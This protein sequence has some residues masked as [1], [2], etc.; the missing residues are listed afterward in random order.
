M[1]NISSFITNENNLFSELLNNVIP[2]TQQV[3]MLVGY[4]YFSG[5]GEIAEALRD[6]DVKILVGLK[7]QTKLQKVIH[8]IDEKKLDQSPPESREKIRLEYFS[9]LVKLFN[10]SEYFDSPDKQKAFELFYEKLKD[11]SLE[12]RKTDN[13]NHA[14]IYLF[15]FEDDRGGTSPGRVITGSSNLTYS[16]LSGRQEFN[17]QLYDPNHYREAKRI[18]KE[19]WDRSTVIA[20]EEY[21]EEFERKV[22]QNIWHNKHDKHTPYHLFLRVLK[23]Y[24]D[25]QENGSI[26][27]CEQLTGGEYTDLK[28]QKDAI[29]ESLAKIKKHDGVIVSDVAGLGK[30]IIA[31]TLAANLNL[32]TVVICPPAI[33]DNWEEYLR[34]FNLKGKAYSSG[35]IE[36]ALNKEIANDHEKLIIIDE[37]HKYRNQETQDY[38]HLYQLC[39]GQKLILLS[40]TPF[41]NRPADIFSLIKFFQVP[42][43]SS[44]QTVENLGQEFRHL[45]SRYKKIN[46][47]R[48]NNELTEEEKNRGISEISERIRD[49]ISPVIIRRSRVDLQK[50]EAY[51]KDLKQQGFQLNKMRPPEGLHYD[52]RDNEKLYVET[53]NQIAEEFEG[54]RY[55][56]ASY[57]DKRKKFK[58]RIK[59]DFGGEQLLVQSQKNLANFMKRHLISRFE[60]SVYAF[61]ISLSRMIRDAEQIKRYYEELDCIPVYK[62]GKLPEVEILEDL[63]AEEADQERQSILAELEDLEDEGLETISRSE[64]A[65]TQFI[66]KLKSDIRLLKKIR[67]EW[68]GN[69]DSTNSLFSKDYKLE[70]FQD[71]LSDKLSENSQRKIVV[72]SE[73]ADTVNYLRKELADRGFHVFSY[74]A[75]DA[76]K[77]N[78]RTIKHNFDANI[79]RDLWEDEYD[80]LLATDTLSEGID[81]NRAGIVV[82]YDIP[83]NP[84]RVI[85]RVG[86]INRIS[87]KLFDE[88]EIYHYFPTAQ[89][90]EEIRKK[91]IATLKMRMMNEI[92]GTDMKVLTDEEDIK[93][94]YE[95][96]IEQFAGEK[97]SWETQY[98][99]ILEGAAQEDLDQA[100]SIPHR[101]RVRRTAEKS[102]N[103]ALVFGKADEDTRFVLC[104]DEDTSE[105]L[106]ARQALELLQADKDEKSERVS[107]G[108][109]TLYENAKKRLYGETFTQPKRDKGKTKTINTLKWLSDNV[110]DEHTDYID[111]LLRV[112]KDF[113]GLTD[114]YEKM[115]RNLPLEEEDPDDCVTNL[116]KE[117]RPE[118][119]HTTIQK[120]QRIKRSEKSLILSEELI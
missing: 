37:A 9:N 106:P 117:L 53:Y 26:K 77:S 114:G 66:P 36:E 41:N 5:F 49:I 120:V 28:Y 58:N 107:G 104:E 95:E 19:M 14:K 11:G 52:L 27:F 112:I 109:Q 63:P 13:P 74:T 43:A 44:I 78:R 97:E 110:A 111:N 45:I 10:D 119:L 46:K 82:N 80:I 102:R 30:S 59:E 75:S 105:P 71:F 57:L 108:F 96:Q 33:L 90:E 84:T 20:D 47:K 65:D 48:R 39:Q 60:S 87:D 55:M 25:V 94:F 32:R 93:S 92:L 115:I 23:E 81:L 62:K 98:I 85:Q 76:T 64:I 34:E 83:Y 40:A 31:S 2:C 42:A 22:V 6:K 91:E 38:G 89:G 3:S 54:A 68:F 24:F 17:V 12:I 88:L 73:S 61:K 29:R 70:D 79:A 72:F 67:R 8:E 1:S 51:R 35:K 99:N 4:F 18:F 16:G 100:K 116:K 56:P 15:E 113:D 69:D 118:V 103:G 101:T 7:V 21:L 50:I 86:R